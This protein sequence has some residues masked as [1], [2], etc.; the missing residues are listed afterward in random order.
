MASIEKIDIYSSVRAFEASLKKLA[1]E[2]G[3]SPENRELLVQ[4]LDD[5]ALGKTIRMKYKLAREIAGMA[6][7]KKGQSVGVRSRQRY[8][9]H[10]KVPAKFFGLKSMRQLKA[11]DVESFV[12]ALET[13]Q[14]SRRDGDPYAAKSKSNIKKTLILFLRWLFGEETE[15]Y[16]EMTYWIDTRY[17]KKSKPCLDESQIRTLLAKCLTIKEKVLIVS[18]FDGGMRIEEFLNVRLGDVVCVAG[19]APYYRMR[20]REEFSKTTGRV[21]PLFWSES[22]E[23]IRQW[24]TFDARTDSEAVFFKC[25]Y[26]AVREMLKRIGGRANIASIHA[27]LFRHSSATHYANEG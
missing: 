2:S 3:I 22:Y 20:V 16:Y 13:N 21:I 18:L 23:I 15:K 11:A 14:L 26:S 19:E 10:L 6:R 7:L 4:F 27:H 5:C 12:R 25:S 8:L 9:Y 24:L 1:Q 17:K